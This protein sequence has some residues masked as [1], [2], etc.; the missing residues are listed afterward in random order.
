M[1]VIDKVC[2]KIMR[3]IPGTDANA[4][5]NIALEKRKMEKKLRAAGLSISQA[6]TEVSLHFRKQ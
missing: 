1:G 6:K 3:S 2:H 5:A 4:A